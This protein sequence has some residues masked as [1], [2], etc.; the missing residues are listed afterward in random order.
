SARPTKITKFIL[1]PKE[2]M[3]T[4]HQ[5]PLSWLKNIG[6]LRK[7]V[8]MSN[9]EVLFIASSHLHGQVEKWWEVKE[10][11]IKIWNDFEQKFKSQFASPQ[12]KEQWWSKIQSL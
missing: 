10:D 5:N 4:S 2:F 7:V 11:K 6:H 3:G 8:E 12:L 1:A 9:E